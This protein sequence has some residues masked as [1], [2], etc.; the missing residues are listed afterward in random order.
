MGR[1]GELS[2]SLHGPHP[3]DHILDARRRRAGAGREEDPEGDFRFGGWQAPVSD[4]SIGEFV[5]E[6]LGEMD[7]L[8]L[9][10]KT[11]D[12]WAA[13]WPHAGREG[14]DGGI[15]TAF[16]AVPK[17]VASR[18]L[19]DPAWRGTTVLGPDLV[20]EVD[21]LKQRHEHIHVWGSLDLLQSLFTE[22]LVDRLDLWAFPLLL[23]DGKKL[24][25]AGVVPAG[26]TLV[27]PPFTSPKGAVLLRYAFPGT[28]PATADMA[29]R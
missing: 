11:Y 4:A 2:G 6:M 16:N 19:V 25:A 5:G 24:F 18:T 9:G 21:A 27:A 26:L 13:Y 22:G 14:Q 28:V 29:A 1:H 7:A 17:Y 15:A 23:G 10:R 20:A 8:L 3:C 12:I